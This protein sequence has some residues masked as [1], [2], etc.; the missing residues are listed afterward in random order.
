MDFTHTLN[1][2]SFGDKGQSKVLKSKFNE[3]M[4][5][6]LNGV[7]IEHNKITTQSN[8]YVSY[9][10]DITEIEIEDQTG[11]KLKVPQYDGSVQ[12]QYPVYTGYKYRS[13]KTV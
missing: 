2:I 5:N 9:Y 6:E 1:E 3:D 8:L 7:S 13:M 4:T 10:L 11:G 12:E